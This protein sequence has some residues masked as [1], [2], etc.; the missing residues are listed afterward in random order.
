MRTGFLGRRLSKEGA[1]TKK[2]AEWYAKLFDDYHDAADGQ[3]G[4][5]GIERLCTALGVNPADVLVL[6]LAWLLGA[7]QMGYFSREEWSAG[8]PILGNATSTDALLD[9]LKAVY[10]ATRRNVDELRRLHKFTHSFC[11]EDRKKNVDASTAIP[12]L[13]LLHG[14][15]FPDHV[16]KMCT[17]LEVCTPRGRESH[18]L[19]ASAI[20]FAGRPSA[21]TDGART[22]TRLRPY[23]CLLS[24]THDTV[25]KRGV[26]M[27]EWSMMLNFFIEIEPDCSNY[28]D[29]GAWPLLLDDYVEWRRE[30]DGKADE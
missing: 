29:D 8:Q 7:S 12:M 2:A 15:A 18:S 20:F 23:A 19:G 5:E 9:T 1:S 22:L 25:G 17:F 14:T 6:V 30:E 16:P 3:I 13:Q 11:R 27:D 28:Q 21:H 24:Q 10:A 26:S 4:P